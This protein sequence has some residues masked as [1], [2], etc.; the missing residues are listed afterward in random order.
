MLQSVIKSFKF[1]KKVLV[2]K[3]KQELIDGLND[4][5]LKQLIIL[6][7]PFRHVMT[8][9]QCGTAPS[10]HLVS[11]SFITLKDTLG[12]YEIVKKYNK[13]NA[14]TSDDGVFLKNLCEDDDVEHELPGNYFSI[15]I[16]LD[17]VT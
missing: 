2:N 10:L 5:Y 17:L 7:N 16:S 1:T 14:D 15:C 6:L 13:E 3:Q 9:I 4:Q 11:L 8:I 12:S